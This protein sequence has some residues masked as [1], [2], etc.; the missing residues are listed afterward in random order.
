MTTSE[1][2]LKLVDYED[3]PIDSDD[4]NPKNTTNDVQDRSIGSKPNGEAT[5]KENQQHDADPLHKQV[6]YEKN[7]YDQS[8]S[9]LSENKN[10]LSPEIL[11]SHSSQAVLK[12]STQPLQPADK[13]QI[14]TTPTKALQ[15][16]QNDTGEPVQSNLDVQEL[17]EKM[18]KVQSTNGIS[19]TKNLQSLSSQEVADDST[20]PLQVASKPQESTSPS[21]ASETVQKV[22]AEPVQSDLDAV[23]ESLLDSVM[24][25]LA[26]PPR[27]SLSENNGNNGCEIVESKKLVNNVDDPI[28]PCSST[29][30]IDQSSSTSAPVMPLKKREVSVT[31]ESSDKDSV[32]LRRSHRS[33]PKKPEIPVLPNVTIPLARCDTL[34]AEV[35]FLVDDIVEQV[36]ADERRAKRLSQPT[37]A[38]KRHRPR[39]TIRSRHSKRRRSTEGSLTE[40]SLQFEDDEAA[41]SSVLKGIV[42]KVV[43]SVGASPVEKH[44]KTASIRRYRRQTQERLAS[45]KAKSEKP[46]DVESV[47]SSVLK[48]IVNKVVRSSSQDS[49]RSNRSESVT[50]EDWADL[51][52]STRS[53][54]KR[55]SSRRTSQR[56]GH[57]SRQKRSTEGDVET[58]VASL[59]KGL[60]RK[61][62][63]MNRDDEKQIPEFDEQ[64]VS[65]TTRRTTR[66]RR[67]SYEP[68]KSRAVR[69]KVDKVQM[70]VASVLEGVLRKVVRNCSKDSLKDPLGRMRLHSVSDDEDQFD[71]DGN[72]IG[73]LHESLLGLIGQNSDSGEWISSDSITSDED[74]YVSALLQSTGDFDIDAAGTEPETEERQREQVKF[75]LRLCVDAV[76]STEAT[77]KAKAAARSGFDCPMC[78]KVCRQLSSLRLH[79]CARHLDYRP[80]VCGSFCKGRFCTLLQLIAHRKEEHENGVYQK[81]RVAYYTKSGL[82]SQMKLF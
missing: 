61:V 66:H 54:S 9:R 22:T 74:T 24:V 15:T 14:S 64:R 12:D 56:A 62:V 39:L 81:V 10:L 40:E 55:S 82:V 80:F 50:E 60:V 20:Q 52:I 25:N 41:V 2:G 38:R 44:V 76:C 77:E 46:E 65:S 42:N 37:P 71:E 79:L 6:S 68:F 48:G 58:E 51:G 1:G 67:I 49:K 75:V 59:V 36:I 53:R 11:Q 70:E 45:I 43:R 35:S 19:E 30:P 21:G 17:S 69:R 16:I 33:L 31:S 27:E 29:T 57:R 73:E 78:K 7:D 23:L 47:V 3:D 4:D 28:M 13:P 8:S 5:I 63:R 34:N 18:E 26:E 72:L 32:V